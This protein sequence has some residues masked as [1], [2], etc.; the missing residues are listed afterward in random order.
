[1]TTDYIPPYAVAEKVT[2]PNSRCDWSGLEDVWTYPALRERWWYCPR[3]FGQN[4]I[5]DDR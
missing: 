2:C 5:E 4:Q 1:M 3:C